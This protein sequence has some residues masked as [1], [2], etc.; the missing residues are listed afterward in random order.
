MVR[1]PVN[2]PRNG[3]YETFEGIIE[4]DRWFGPLITNIRLTKTDVPIDFRADFPLLQVQPIPRNAYDDANA[5]KTNR[6][7]QRRSASSMPA[8]SAAGS[9]STAATGGTTSS[10]TSSSASGAASGAASTA[11]AAGSTSTGPPPRGRVVIIDDR[12]VFERGHDRGRARSVHG[13][14]RQGPPRDQPRAIRRRDPYCCRGSATAMSLGAAGGFKATGAF[15]ASV[16]VGFG[17]TGVFKATTGGF[18]ANASMGAGFGA[19]AFGST[20]GT[21]ESVWALDPFS[22]GA[23]ASV[24]AKVSW[25]LGAAT[26]GG[27]WRARLSAASGLASTRA[28]AWPRDSI[29]SLIITPRTNSMQATTALPKNRKKTWRLSSL[30]SIFSRHPPHSGR[31]S[32]SAGPSMLATAVYRRAHDRPFR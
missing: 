30:T 16:G 29:R 32:S 24:L 21:N 23:P 8:S 26:P 31:S 10:P 15:G 7:Q 28:S 2:I 20:L 19:G 5:S 4:T 3:N 22:L 17:A 12:T 11:S 25:G 6:N 13:A 9:S 27:G 18:G 14:P 1:A